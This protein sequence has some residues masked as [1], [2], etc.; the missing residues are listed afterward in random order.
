MTIELKDK[1]EEKCMCV[2]LGGHSFESR[3]ILKNKGSAKIFHV[4]Q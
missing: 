1:C 2:S 3:G 4:G